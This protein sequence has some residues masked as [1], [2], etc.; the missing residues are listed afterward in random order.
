MAG[1]IENAQEAR[2]VQFEAVQLADQILRV[3]EPW[4]TAGMPQ[5]AP[6]IDPVVAGGLADRVIALNAWAAEHEDD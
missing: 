5:P 4:V 3:V 1:T 6:V 2:N